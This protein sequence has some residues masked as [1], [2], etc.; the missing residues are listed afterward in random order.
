MAAPKGNDFAKG[1]S[2]GDGAP[3]GNGRAE[4]H[5]MTADSRKWFERHRDD[6][7]DRVRK[8]VA[9]AVKQVPFDW[10]NLMKMELLVE[11]AIN[12]EQVRYGD[13]YIREQGIIREEVTP[14]GDTVVVRDEENPA[15]L[16]KSRLQRDT[17]RL[18]KEL[19]Y[20]DDPDS[21]QAESMQSIAEVLS[22]DIS[23]ERVGDESDSDEDSDGD[24]EQQD[25]PEPAIT[26]ATWTAPEPEPDEGESADESTAATDSDHDT[27]H[28]ISGTDTVG[29]DGS[30]DFELESEET[31]DNTVRRF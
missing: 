28:T 19:G 6:V 8:K 27:E 9:R 14:T 13:E 25:A 4:T 16:Q 22:V 15:S 29:F 2:G 12:Q 17:I 18:L 31:T 5:G 21:Q 24:S 10:Q 23:H 3:E 30:D 7:G 26:P 1:N 20:L 11:A